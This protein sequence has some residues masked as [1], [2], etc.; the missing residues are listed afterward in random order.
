MADL[1]EA[2]EQLYALAE[3]LG[4]A[5]AGFGEGATKENCYLVYY[6]ENVHAWDTKDC[7]MTADSNGNLT[8][9]YVA[10]GSE[11]AS[12]KIYN[13]DTKKYHAVSASVDLV[14][15]FSQGTYSLSPFSSYSSSS[16][17]HSITIRGMTKGTKVVFTY[18]P[19]L[20]SLSI[21]CAQ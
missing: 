15:P 4:K 2:A 19:A 3:K 16:G 8:Y 11:T 1:K 17:A 10:T 14:Y 6:V 5:G 13:Q 12:F 9:T 7:K 21:T 18:N 20:D